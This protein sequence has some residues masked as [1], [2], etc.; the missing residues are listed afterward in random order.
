MVGGSLHTVPGAWDHTEVQAYPPC[1]AQGSTQDRRCPPRSLMG[2]PHP[3]CKTMVGPC[4]SPTAAGRNT[5]AHPLGCCLPQWPSQQTSGVLWSRSGPSPSSSDTSRISSTVSGKLMRCLSPTDCG[6]RVESENA[7]PSLCSH[8]QPPPHAQAQHPAVSAGPGQ[9]RSE[10]L[11]LAAPSPSLAPQGPGP[12][13]QGL[14]GMS[15][16]SVTILSTS[17]TEM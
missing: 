11:C 16:S 15:V 2:S 12:S 7:S 17:V 4:S 14:T 8:L 3:L 9:L 6:S 10:D 5:S 1:I 13:P